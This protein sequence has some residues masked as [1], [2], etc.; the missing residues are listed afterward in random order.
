[1]FQYSSHLNHGEVMPQDPQWI[2]NPR[3]W[4]PHL[5]CLL[6]N[7]AYTWYFFYVCV[8]CFLFYFFYCCACGGTC[9]IYESSYRISKILYL[10]SPLPP[11]S[12]IL[13]H[14]IPGIL[15][16]GLICP[17]TYM[18]T[19][20]LH[21]IYIPILFPHLLPLPLVP[22]PPDRTCSFLLFYDFVK[23]KKWYFCSF[24]IATGSFLVT[25]PGI[26]VW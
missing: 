17:F 14:S 5:Y 24:K 11:F 15:S 1:M 8:K 10:N 4:K 26:Y 25:F 3:K 16:T 23:E 21:H 22:K 13:P 2:S 9:G 12:I 19:Q 20:Y 7:G 18:C 6:P